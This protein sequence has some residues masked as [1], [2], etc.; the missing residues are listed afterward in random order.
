M[1]LSAGAPRRAQK[2]HTPSSPSA[3]LGAALPPVVARYSAAPPARRVS[4]MGRAERRSGRAPP[5]HATPSCRCAR[6]SCARA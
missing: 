3:A 1:S 6:P 4:H 5:A 2:P